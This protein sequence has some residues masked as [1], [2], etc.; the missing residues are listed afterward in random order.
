MESLVQICRPQWWHALSRQHRQANSSLVEDVPA[1]V[2]QGPVVQLGER[3]IRI[4][5]VSGSNPLGSIPLSNPLPMPPSNR[6]DEEEL[7]PRH[8]IFFLFIRHLFGRAF[9]KASGQWYL[10]S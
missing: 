3:R 8:F 9:K 6:D 2:K 4:A 7:N 5:E 10:L 1:L